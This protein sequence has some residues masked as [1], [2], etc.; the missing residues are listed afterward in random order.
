MKKR[1]P[2]L[3][4]ALMLS[5]CLAG[6]GIG[7]SQKADAAT[8]SDYVPVYEVFRDVKF[9]GLRATDADKNPEQYIWDNTNSFFTNGNAATIVNG[10]DA[11]S[12]DASLLWK[13]QAN[14]AEGWTMG[15][16]GISD[17]KIVGTEG[18]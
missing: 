16:L 7:V 10:A 8:S 2:Y 3:L 9:E 13:P 15:T 12:G 6:L 1:R 18:G 17:K 5:L 11:L 4:A 14:D